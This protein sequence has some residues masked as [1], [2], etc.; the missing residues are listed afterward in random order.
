[1]DYELGGNRLLNFNNIQDIL[2]DIEYLDWE[3]HLYDTSGNS[4]YMQIHFPSIDLETKESCVVHSRK[5]M[6]SMHMTKSEIVQTALMATLAAI[7]HEARENFRYQGKSIFG[8]H[9]NVDILHK[10]AGNV[11]NLDMRTGEWVNP[12]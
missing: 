4:L 3:Y 7:E 8:P 9:Y 10:V 1:M 6:I 2:D 12:T 5:W 11:A